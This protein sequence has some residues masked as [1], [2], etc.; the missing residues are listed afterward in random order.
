MNRALWAGIALLVAAPA[1]YGQAAS[2]RA[3]V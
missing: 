3:G 2:V 1:A